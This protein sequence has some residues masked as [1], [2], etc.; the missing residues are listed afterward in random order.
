MFVCINVYLHFTY[1]NDIFM[2]NR[3]TQILH[4]NFTLPK[5]FML[6]TENVF[7]RQNLWEMFTKKNFRLKAIENSQMRNTIYV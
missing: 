6:G 2:C 3:D 7:I 1:N 5:T 4:N